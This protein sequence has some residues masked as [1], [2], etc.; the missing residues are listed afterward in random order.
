MKKR[1]SLHHDQPTACPEAEGGSISRRLLGDETGRGGHQVE[2]Q[3]R[4][5]HTGDE[6]LGI[7]GLDCLGRIVNA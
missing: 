5:H 6:E 7:E 4:H 2:N 1:N 3:E